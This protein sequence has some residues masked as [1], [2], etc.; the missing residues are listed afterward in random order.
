MKSH[1]C[2]VAIVLHSTFLHQYGVWICLPIVRF[3]IFSKFSLRQQPWSLYFCDL[4]STFL[5]GDLTSRQWWREKR[6]CFQFLEALI[7]GGDKLRPKEHVTWS[8]FQ[9]GHFFPIT[10]CPKP[11]W[12]NK[13]SFMSIQIVLEYS[14]PTV[15]SFL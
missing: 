15:P 5:P 2:L 10:S 8:L 13:V 1:M 14:S 3:E 7:L 9:G 12:G 6:N 11:C 4:S